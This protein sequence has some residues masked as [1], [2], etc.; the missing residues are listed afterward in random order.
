MELKFETKENVA[1]IHFAGRM[2]VHFVNRV[3]EEFNSIISGL[4]NKVLIINLEKVDYISS[5]ALRIFVTTLKVCDE[6]DI[7]LKLSSLRPA[8]VKIF[9]L[10]EMTSLFHIYNSLPEALAQK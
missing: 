6:K 9:D 10:V 8:V 7:T 1:I 3:E 2:D 4:N 5:S